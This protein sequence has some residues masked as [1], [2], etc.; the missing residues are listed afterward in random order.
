MWWIILGALGLVCGIL[1]ST[2]LSSGMLTKQKRT[3][4]L[5]IIILVIAVICFGI[6]FALSGVSFEQNL[7]ADCEAALPILND[8]NFCPFCGADLEGLVT[9][10]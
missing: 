2:Y 3:R 9:Y 10:D 6:A 8:W 1:G 5:G 7:C 4:N